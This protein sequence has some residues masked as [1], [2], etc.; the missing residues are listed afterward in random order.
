[1][2]PE[3]SV[4]ANLSIAKASIPP[5]SL[6][7]RDTVCVLTDRTKVSNADVSDVKG[8]TTSALPAKAAS[9]YSCPGWAVM[10]DSMSS[11]AMSMREVSEV[12]DMSCTSM[13][14]EVSITKR[15]LSPAIA[16]EVPSVPAYGMIITR[17]T[18]PTDTT[19]AVRRT[20]R[21]PACRR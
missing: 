3:W 13:L 2:A 14:R 19:S 12:R 4:G 16:C 8:D 9:P 18:S 11:F 20:I 21:Y 10:I 7:C 6:P 1:M 15:I 5:I 17:R